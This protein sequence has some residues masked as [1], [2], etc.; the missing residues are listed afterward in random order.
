[1]KTVIW[2]LIFVAAA[3]PALM[4]FFQRWRQRQAEKKG[5]VVYATVV[6]MEAIKRFGKVLPMKKITLSIQEPGKDR[7][8]VTLRTQIAEGQTIVPGM[9]LSV[10]VDPKNPNR[11][12][13]AGDEAAKRLVITGPRRERRQLRSGRGVTRGGGVPGRRR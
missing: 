10:V 6:S 11:I 2:T 5:V 13:P 12:Y 4:Y 1:M 7:R 3:T 8:S 9:L